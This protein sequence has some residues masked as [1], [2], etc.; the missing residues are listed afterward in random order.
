MTQALKGDKSFIPSNK[1]IIIP[2][3]VINKSNV[4]DF[5]KKSADLLRK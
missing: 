4:E 5:S 2:T 1:Q 3:M